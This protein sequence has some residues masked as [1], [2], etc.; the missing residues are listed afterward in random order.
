MDRTYRLL[1][2]LSS[3]FGYVS[4][5]SMNTCSLQMST[6][7]NRKFRQYEPLILRILPTP[8]PLDIILNPNL[9]AYPSLHRPERQKIFLFILRSMHLHRTVL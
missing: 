6:I 4:I 5:R 9:L 2:M 1:I 3:G 8:I 7:E